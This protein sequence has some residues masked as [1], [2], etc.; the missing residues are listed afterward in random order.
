MKNNADLIKKIFLVLVFLILL[1]SLFTVQYFSGSEKRRAVFSEP[2]VPSN[3]TVKAIDLGL[4]NAAADFYWLSAIQYLGGGQSRTNEKLADYLFLSTSLDPKFSYP[5]AF[6]VLILPSV[7]QTDRGI[8]LAKTGLEK[9]EPDWEIPYYLA[10]T[11]HIDKNDTASAAKYFDLAAHTPN[12]PAN[13]ARVAATYGSRPD[14]RSQTEAIWQ[15]I[16][17]NSTDSVVKE[18]AGNYLIH[19]QLLDFLENSAKE[20]QKR[21]GKLPTTPQDL[22]S[23]KILISIPADPLGFEYAFDSTGRAVIK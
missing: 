1:I 18:R 8:E 19:F 7:N 12:A 15:G 3:A 21:Y 2:V 14:L 11:Y 23:G 17:D 4:D 20:Y 9:A 5:Y 6:G 13:I 10:T 22:V 16:Y